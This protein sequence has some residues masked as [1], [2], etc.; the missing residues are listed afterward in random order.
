MYSGY[1]E[2]KSVVPDKFI[3]T[4]KNKNF[5]RKTA[6]SMNVYLDVLD[7]IVNKYNSKSHSIIK[8]KPID[9]ISDSYS[10]YNED[11]NVTK[12]KFKVGDHVGISKYKNIFAKGYT[13]NWW[14][15]VLV[16]SKIKIAVPW[17]YV[18][19]DLNGEPITGSFYEKELQITSK[20]KFRIEKVI[21]RKADKLFVKWK[22]YDNLSKSRIGKNDLQ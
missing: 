22:E 10:E 13:Q 6:I 16:V 12:P 2:G 4:T 19:S 5:K 18:I 21:K 15:E 11:S 1:N 9:V 14:E 17:T 20:E 7:D 3:R 8:M